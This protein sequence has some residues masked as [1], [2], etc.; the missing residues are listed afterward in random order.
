MSIERPPAERDDAQDLAVL[1]PAAVALLAT[2][3]RRA[4]GRPLVPVV[5][6]WLAAV[7]AYGLLALVVLL[8]DHV[9]PAL[10]GLLPWAVAPAARAV[11]A[12]G[13]PGLWAA[14]L[15]VGLAMYRVAAAASRP[16]WVDGR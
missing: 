11:A 2:E 9:V 15:L 4:D 13:Q 12:F 6:V 5:G 7:H 14:L 1:L 8:N 3:L 16:G 10:N